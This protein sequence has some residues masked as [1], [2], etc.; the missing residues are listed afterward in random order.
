V[1]VR[2]E[3]AAQVKRAAGIAAETV[4]VADDCSLQELAGQVAAAHGEALQ[5]LLLDE[6]GGLQP[7]IL[8][9]V[10]DEQ[11]RGDAARV[12]NGRDTVTFLSPISGG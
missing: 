1:D 5:K 12:L 6:G 11:V 9:F 2:V 10:G 7:S 8:I 4:A 3:Y